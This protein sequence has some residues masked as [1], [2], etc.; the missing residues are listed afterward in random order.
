MS[1]ADM[2]ATSFEVSYEHTP[3]MISSIYWASL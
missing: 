3:E 1:S 2:T